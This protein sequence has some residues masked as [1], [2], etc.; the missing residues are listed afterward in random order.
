[1]N[2]KKI[3]G[4]HPLLYFIIFIFL[5][6]LVKNPQNGGLEGL[7]NNNNNELNSLV[8]EY[9]KSSTGIQTRLSLLVIGKKI[10]IPTEIS[11]EIQEN[12]RLKKKLT[13]ILSKQ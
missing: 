5:F 9:M 10:K 6:M 12:K 4:F 1:M 7:E 3:F 11:N 2:L 8:K 13:D